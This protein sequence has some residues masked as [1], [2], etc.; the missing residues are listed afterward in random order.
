MRLHEIVLGSCR[1]Q[2]RGGSPALPA[3][4]PSSPAPHLT[5]FLSP[6]R[7]AAEDDEE[8]D[9]GAG[10]FFDEDEVLAGAAAASLGMGDVEEV[11]L[12]S[13]DVCGS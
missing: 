7:P 4:A 5:I 12:F 8:E 6:A 2:A 10:V 1:G 3:A 13:F 11:R 9:E